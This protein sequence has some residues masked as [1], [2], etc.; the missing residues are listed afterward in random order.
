[1][2]I[3]PTFKCNTKY[4]IVS[5]IIIWYALVL[6]DKEDQNNIG[7]R[8]RTKNYVKSEF[9]PCM[10][11]FFFPRPP[12]ATQWKDLANRPSRVQH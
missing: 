6:Y 11:K 7:N 1:M 2:T 10:V 5:C 12:I 4:S 3:F 8:Y 9:L